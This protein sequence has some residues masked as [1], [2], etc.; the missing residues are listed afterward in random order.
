MSRIVFFVANDLRR[1]SRALREAASLAAH[2]HDVTVVGVLSPETV[3]AEDVGGVRILRAK[4]VRRP[5]RLWV[6]TTWADEQRTLWEIARGRRRLG[7]R[8]F[9][10]RLTDIVRDG[11][12]GH[13]PRSGAALARARDELSRTTGKWAG[14]TRAVAS[15]IVVAPRALVCRVVD[16]LTGGSADWYAAWWAAWEGWANEALAISPAADVWAVND[17]FTIPAGRRAQD[18][19]G[20]AIV[21]HVRDLVI[22]SG[23]YLG[24]ARWARA[25]LR[26]LERDVVRRS[27]AVVTTTAAMADWIRAQDRPSVPVVV[28]HNCPPRPGPA[29]PARTGV[30]RAAAGL[31]AD[32]RVAMYA[33]GLR[34]GRGIEQFLEALRAPALAGVHGILFGFGELEPG[35]RRLAEEGPYGGRLHVV[36]ALPLDAYQA[37]LADADV[38][39][40]LFQPDTP[41]HRSVI[42]NKLF[43]ALAAGVPVV[44]SDT[45]GLRGVLLGDPSGPLGAVCDPTDPTAIAAAIGS[46]LDMPADAREALRDRCHRAAFERWNW[47]HEVESYL[48]LFDLPVAGDRAAS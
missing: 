9:R 6:R 18:R 35:L 44:A 7:I 38:A 30:L 4:A 36:A 37:A 34:S 28:T 14:W 41:S 5:H 11:V 21:Y 2:G 19:H 8:R 3:P 32:D 23:P 24:R 17:I 12:I 48:P 10:R 43:E 16:A 47:E 26:R 39:L 33:G 31:T 46:I 40:A 1:E 15:A 25:S 13:L 22:D 42:P 27:V 45:P 29:R 20:G